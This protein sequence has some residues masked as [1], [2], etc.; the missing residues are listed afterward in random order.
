MG[1][2]MEVE[3]CLPHLLLS[4]ALRMHRQLGHALGGWYGGEGEA[5]N[6]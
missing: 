4:V 1:I 5:A 6:A 2:W 3:P